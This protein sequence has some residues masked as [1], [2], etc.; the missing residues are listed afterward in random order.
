MIIA[1][2]IL[3]GKSEY[4]S[5]AFLIRYTD[6]EVDFNE[7]CHFR[8]EYDAYPSYEV[9]YFMEAELLFSDLS[10]GGLGSKVKHI[11]K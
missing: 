11:N 4:V 2:R 3:E 9:T 8:A 6:E 7:V 10:S 1:P 5:R